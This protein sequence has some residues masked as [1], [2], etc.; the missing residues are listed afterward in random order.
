MIVSGAARAIDGIAADL[1]APL[2]RARPGASAWRLVGWDGEQGLQVTLGRGKALVLVEFEPRDDTRD[3]CARTRRFNVCARRAFDAARPLGEA[4]RRAVDAV[5]TLVR[6]REGRLPVL[7]RSAT[8]RRSLLRE[9][10][11]SRVLIPEGAGHYYINPYVGCTIGCSFCYVAARAD[12]SRSLEGLPELPWGRYVDVKLNAAEVLRREVRAYPPGI[13]RFSPILTDPYQPLERRYRITRRCLEVLL[14][15]GFSPVILTR[16]GLVQEDLELLRRF[17]A[18]AVGLSV[19]TDNDRERQR[20]EPGADPIDERLAVLER[21]H[22]SGLRTFGVI[23]PILP[24]DPER[25]AAQ[26]APHV[27]AVRVD[28]MYERQ[29]TRRL[30]E[31]AGI[32]EAALDA[33]FSR[34]GATLRAAFAARGVPYDAMDDLAGLLGLRS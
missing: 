29:R 6:A 34:T 18:A 7:E 16:A 14:P 4:E 30:Y 9:V 33:F 10:S 17:P 8:G 5:V 1:L 21:L 2:I 12:M 15:A 31:G 19:P 32:P 11:V 26:L 27:D 20:F 23:Q 3:C 28:R 25:L 24:M 13:V 22:A